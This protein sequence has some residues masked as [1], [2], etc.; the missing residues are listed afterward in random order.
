VL[1]VVTLGRPSPCLSLIPRINSRC[2]Y[3]LSELSAADN[4]RPYVAWKRCS[5]CIMEIINFRHHGLCKLMKVGRAGG[6]C[7][8]YQHP[9]LSFIKIGGSS[10]Q[11]ME[12]GVVINGPEQ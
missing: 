1:P 5:T 7:K 8:I 2:V 11:C 9:S 4:F 6:K 3:V 12:S 10:S